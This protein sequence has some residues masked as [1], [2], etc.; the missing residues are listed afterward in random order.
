MS[1]LKE[2]KKLAIATLRAPTGAPLNGSTPSKS[3]NRGG[4]KDRKAAAAAAAAR[5]LEPPST[6]PK[7]PPAVGVLRL[8][9][10]RIEFELDVDPFWTIVKLKTG[11]TRLYDR[12]PALLPGNE[13]ASMTYL[14]QAMED[15]K[16]GRL[17][18]R[19]DDIAAELT[20]EL[21]HVKL[22][23]SEQG[24]HSPRENE[25]SEVTWFAVSFLIRKLAARQPAGLFRF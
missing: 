17:R 9:T 7:K 8:W 25:E 4:K 14:A 24:S 15:E 12:F 21:D 13:L 23:V 18:E 16:D 11:I 10:I 3:K 6:G 2:A 22:K 19:L 20:R 5:L 1:I